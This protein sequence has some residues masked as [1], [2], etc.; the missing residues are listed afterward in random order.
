MS[1]TR[2]E[3]EVPIASFGVITD[4]QYADVDD[5]C[6]N[7]D[8][9]KERYYRTSLKLVAEAVA[10]WQEHKKAN[11]LKFILQLG[12]VIDVKASK[13]NH[14]D[15]ALKRVLDE[16]EKADVPL[17]SCWGNHEMYN[18]MRNALVNTPLNSARFLNPEV[19][20]DANFYV[21]DVSE[22]FKIVCLDFYEF[23]IIGYDKS[24]DMHKAA[25]SFLKRHNSNSELHSLKGLVG[26]EKRFTGFNG[27]ISTAQFRWLDSTLNGFKQNGVRAIVCGHLPIH[28][29]ATT[30]VKCLAWNYED[31]L[32]L[33]HKFDNTVVAY[34][35]GHDH[36][37]G[38]FRDEYNIY[39]LTLK[40]I[41]EAPE[42]KNAYAT[43]KV[44]KNR[45]VIKGEGVIS[46]YE[47][48]FKN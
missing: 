42:G 30:S 5:G 47:I 36:D 32:N 43:I 46:S 17:Y 3:A 8:P 18:Y 27:A 23:S 6:A 39:H 19:A 34:L 9:T 31:V 40:A 28:P 22:C 25:L 12:D 29:A 24:D 4:V 21:I 44:F 16:F 7:Y 15:E 11:N 48:L 26:L 37:G 13:A 33:L 14:R 2:F 45:A 20:N 41:L 38:A 35:A 10:D 1:E